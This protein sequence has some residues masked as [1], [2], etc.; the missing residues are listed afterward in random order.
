MSGPR[1]V[2]PPRGT[3]LHCKNWQLE[4]PFR[5][6][7]HN[8]DPEVAERPEDL[9][10]YGGRGQAARDWDSF[11]AIAVAH[12]AC[13]IH[14]SVFAAFPF[15][16][17]VARPCFSDIQPRSTQCLMIPFKVSRK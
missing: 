10:V 6:I 14:H 15:F 2:H 11:D 4:A 8:L 7:Q 1:I 9:V 17:K 16:N 13:K 5:M 12:I 3:Q